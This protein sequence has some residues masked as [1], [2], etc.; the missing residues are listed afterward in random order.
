L[1]AVD[2]V[3][4]DTLIRA[5]EDRGLQRL[6]HLLE[7]GVDVHIQIVLVPGVN[8][9]VVLEESLSWLAE[10]E[11]VLSVGLVPLGFT[12]FQSRF[13]ASYD[14][15][16]AAAIIDAVQPWQEAFLE[17]D[18]VRRVYLA[19]E[20]YL[21]AGRT[22]PP[23]EAYDGYPQF[24]NGIGL[25]RSF[26]DDMSELRSEFEAA[27]SALTNGRVVA[28]LTGELFAPV[29]KSALAD[30]RSAS[31]RVLP[32]KN[33]FFGGNVSVAGLLTSA[34]ILAA[35][36]TLCEPATVLVPSVVANADGL[37]LDDVAATE[38]SARSAMEVRLISCDA[39]G[40]LEALQAL[41]ADTPMTPKE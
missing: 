20:L 12:R 40:L 3:V 25:V 15:G 9:G 1:H 32:V 41:A 30:L 13:S 8:D 26:L 18:G 6:D 14:S 16:E 33:R 7:E 39:G 11:G 21:T 38:L 27:V 34:D 31:V 24:E 17:R 29:L 2:P 28:L 4:R 10:R 23:A 35:I 22:L 5:N 19:D 36:D 37:L